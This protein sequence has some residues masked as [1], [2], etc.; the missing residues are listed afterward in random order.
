MVKYAPK[1]WIGLGLGQS[2]GNVRIGEASY[3]KRLE[4][5]KTLQKK[6]LSNLPAS[7]VLSAIQHHGVLTP[8][9]QWET[10]TD[11]NGVATDSN[12]VA[13][14]STSNTGLLALAM[15]DC[16]LA[17]YATDGLGLGLVDSFGVMHHIYQSKKVV[18]MGD[19]DS[20]VAWSINNADSKP[21]RSLV[22]DKNLT[23]FFKKMKTLSSSLPALPDSSTFTHKLLNLGDE[24][25]SLVVTIL[26]IKHG[27]KG[28]EGYM[29]AY[30]L[31]P[32]IC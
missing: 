1:D 23:D 20:I 32:Q 11:S 18:T 22:T 17:Q 21:E 30:S 19:D 5:A 16:E 29:L 10:N 6:T 24:I 15:K 13:T 14:D 2:S 27:E 8:D 25:G 3:S 12:G 9:A 28:E 4:L 31:L 7:L 26:K